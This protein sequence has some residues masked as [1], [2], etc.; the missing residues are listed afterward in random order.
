MVLE[1]TKIFMQMQVF[2]HC[3]HCWCCISLWHLQSIVTICHEYVCPLSSYIETRQ[4]SCHFA[5]DIF[6]CIFFN[7]NV[8]IVN[9]ISLKFVPIGPI[10]NMPAL[11]QIMAWN[12]RHPAIFCTNGGL[13]YWCIYTQ[14][15]WVNTANAGRFLKMSL[16]FSNCVV[17]S[18][19]VIK[20]PQYQNHQKQ[21]RSV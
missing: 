2:F 20:N 18:I 11:I 6:K 14:P 1:N 4:N 19:T 9:E 8:S 17:I 16:A 7:E 10:D 3:S 13:L 15:Q 5:D 12:R 21:R